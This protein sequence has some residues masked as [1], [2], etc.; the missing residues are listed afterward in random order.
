MRKSIKELKDRIFNLL[1]FNFLVFC[2]F[3][4]IKPT[5][6]NNKFAWLLVV[7]GVLIPT[8]VFLV[9]KISNSVWKVSALASILAFV[10]ATVLLISFNGIKR[11]WFTVI[12]LSVAGILGFIVSIAEWKI[13]S[14]HI[15]RINQKLSELNGADNE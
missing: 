15:E 3:N 4:T 11:P 2:V 6:I 1:G 7:L 9:G 8:E 10:T 12:I 5:V 13:R 14:W